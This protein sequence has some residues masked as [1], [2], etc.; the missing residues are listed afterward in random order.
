MKRNAS[1]QG[2]GTKMGTVRAIDRMGVSTITVAFSIPGILLIGIFTSI[3]RAHAFIRG[4]LFG[5]SASLA[6]GV[7]LV[8]FRA[9]FN[10]DSIKRPP[11]GWLVRLADRICR[12]STSELIGPMVADMRVEC[13]EAL[14]D[15]HRLKA[16]WLK[17]LHYFYISR[18]LSID[19]VVIA[20]VNYLL[21]TITRK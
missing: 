8:L 12:K 16:A 18:A 19:R 15:G 11:G 13:F 2:V 5:A 3:D 17:V 9:L 14:Q 21:G 7:F 1:I 6:V 10:R 4:T 20:V